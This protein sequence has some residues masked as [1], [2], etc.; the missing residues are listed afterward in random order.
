MTFGKFD[1]RWAVIVLKKILFLVSQDL[2]HRVS[3]AAEDG[4]YLCMLATGMLLCVPAHA[5]PISVG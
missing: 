4:S 3:L 5:L 2:G 1:G